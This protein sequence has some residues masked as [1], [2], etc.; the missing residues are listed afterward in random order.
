MKKERL[1]HSLYVKRMLPIAIVPRYQLFQN[2]CLYCI[3]FGKFG[4]HYIIAE[5][6]LQ[7]LLK[8]TWLNIF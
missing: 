8:R 3:T 5:R 7:L 6:N 2:Y 1:I 4:Y